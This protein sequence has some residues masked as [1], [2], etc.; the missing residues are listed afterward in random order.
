MANESLEHYSCPFCGTVESNEY[1]Q[2]AFTSFCVVQC[3]TCQLWYVSPPQE[4]IEA[5]ELNSYAQPIYSNHY[6]DR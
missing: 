4:E 2:F 6:L 3:P 1:Q 5:A